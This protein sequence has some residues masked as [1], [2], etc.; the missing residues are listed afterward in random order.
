MSQSS[1]RSALGRCKRLVMEGSSWKARH[2]RLVMGGSS[3][4]A[5]HGRL[6]MEGSSWKARHGRLVMEGSSWKARHGR[7]VME[8]SSPELP[9]THGSAF[10]HERATSVPTCHVPGPGVKCIPA[11]PASPP[12]PRGAHRAPPGPYVPAP[13]PSE[14]ASRRPARHAPAQTRRRRLCACAC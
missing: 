6:V 7:L 2:G 1:H 12:P 11:H 8:G 5:R 13:G 3:W 14:C 10:S 9:Q 4:K